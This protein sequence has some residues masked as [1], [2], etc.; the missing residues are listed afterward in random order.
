[1]NSPL[2]LVDPAADVQV[3]DQE[4]FRLLGFPRGHQLE[5]RALELAQWTRTWYAAH[6]RP[7]VYARDRKSVV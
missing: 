6:G 5:G 4:Y 1:M 3:D 2:L 7:W